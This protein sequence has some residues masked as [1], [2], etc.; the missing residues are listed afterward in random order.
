[1]HLLIRRLLQPGR[2]AIR[3][4]W[5][6]SAVLSLVLPVV[7]TV[8]AFG[9]D[10]SV[11]T[12]ILHVAF[13]NRGVMSQATID[14]LVQTNANADWHQLTPEYHF[15]SAP[16]ALEVCK[17]YDAGLKQ[18]WAR[19]MDA[20]EP[21]G[22]NFEHLKD[23]SAAATYY[24]IVTHEIEDFYSHSNWVEL[25]LA[26][27]DNAYTDEAPL[28]D[29][30]TSGC[31]VAALP[32]NLQTGY[33]SLGSLPD[34]CPSSGPPDGFGYCHSQ[35]AKDSLDSGHGA[36]T[37]PG[38][39]GQ[40]VNYHQVAVLLAVLTTRSS[41]EMLRQDYSL[42]YGGIADFNSECGWHT[43]GFGGSVTSCRTS[44][45]ACQ[46][47]LFRDTDA[48]AAHDGEMVAASVPMAQV[49]CSAPTNTP[50]LTPTA[51][52]KPL[53]YYV[54]VL[55]G[56]GF[57]IG[58]DEQVATT[59]SCDYAGGGRCPAASAPATVQTRYAGPF[60]SIAAAK[61]DLKTKLECRNGYWG[62]QAQWGSGGTGL[63]AGGWHWLQNNV[64]LSDCKKVS[65]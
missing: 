7:F 45:P 36:E 37:V 17:R 20:L 48:V 22:A 56:I 61:A 41:W 50:L 53:A 28:L 6:V 8:P 15:D 60:P 51:T 12:G 46:N 47:G 23:P 57:Y 52:P 10:T 24:G 9:F 44:A 58:T 38:P 29:M 26:K 40:N 63:S 14:L 42:R 65:Q 43:V 55:S 13:D 49:L 3:R 54:F 5:C 16:D 35:L 1:M 33:F 4:A 34:G 11:H 2:H 19:T 39:P 32:P 30:R 31:D 64:D 62:P 18:D 25:S 59:R 21:T 27:Y